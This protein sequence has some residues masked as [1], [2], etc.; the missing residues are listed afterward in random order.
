MSQNFQAVAQDIQF[1]KKIL[2]GDQLSQSEFEKRYKK[3]NQYCARYCIAKNKQMEMTKLQINDG[4]HGEEILEAY[5]WMLLYL[6]KQLKKYNGKNSLHT[7]LYNYVNINSKD[8]YIISEYNKWKYGNPYNIPVCI[9]KH[10]KILH[11]TFSQLYMNKNEEQI[12]VFINK[13]LRDEKEEK[14]DIQERELL[15]P[16]ILKR[17]EELT[18]HKFSI[19]NFEDPRLEVEEI[20]I[21]IDKVKEILDKADIIYKIEYHSEISIS[22]FEGG[23]NENWNSNYIDSI[24]VKEA[25]ESDFKDSTLEDLDKVLQRY[26]KSVGK[27]IEQEPD[28][29]RLLYARINS[30]LTIDKILENFKRIN[31]NLPCIKKKIQDSTIKDVY[32]SIERCTRKC[33]KQLLY[34]FSEECKDLANATVSMDAIDM[35][36][37]TIGLEDSYV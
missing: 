31:I 2:N 34:F 4:L 6:F 13:K 24:M 1:V 19:Q 15:N 14:L 37:E 8:Q 25:A 16:N 28:I 33:K 7:F 23:V 17:L 18:N 27:F 29:F 26:N 5:N 21:L 10:P 36:F 32:R 3:S 30:N 11:L 20:S 35:L 12:F 9:K 22:T